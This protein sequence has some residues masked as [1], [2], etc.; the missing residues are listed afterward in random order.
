MPVHF[1]RRDNELRVLTGLD[2]IKSK[3]ARA[4]GRATLCVEMTL[5]GTDRRYVTAEGPV[6]VEEPVLL[7]DVLA[8]AERLAD[9]RRARLLRPP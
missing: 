4:S 6:R 7:E 3:N 5:D 1:V 8:L 2:S 9:T